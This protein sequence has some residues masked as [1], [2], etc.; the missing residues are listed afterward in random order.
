MNR[1]AIVFTSCMLPVLFAGSGAAVES[2]Q[3][4]VDDP[5][6][7]GS[8]YEK[9]AYARCD[10]RTVA[11]QVKRG[12]LVVDVTLRGKQSF[13]NTYLHLNTKGKKGSE[14]EFVVG[15]GEP[16]GPLTKTGGIDDFGAFEDPK[17]KGEVPVERKDGGKVIEFR[18]PLGKIGSPKTTGF[19][20]RTCGEG[21]VDIAPGGDHF[22]DRNYTGRPDFQHKNIETG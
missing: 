11:A 4:S 21:A 13:P 2:G 19:Q 7:S 12:K 1:L 10:I 14:P 20:A 18:V 17:E 9:S 15:P 3:V 8:L 5:K 6:D 16:K 22:D